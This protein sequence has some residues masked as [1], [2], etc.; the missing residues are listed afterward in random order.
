MLLNRRRFMVLG[1]GAA[2]AV[3]VPRALGAGRITPA[4]AATPAPA[5]AI[6]PFAAVMP[7]PPVAVPVSVRGGTDVYRLSVRQVAAEILPGHPT[8]VLSYGSGLIGPTIRA[9]TGRPTVVTVDS[10]VADP[11]NVHLHG[12]H[13]APED[14][15]APMDTIA[16]GA[17]RHYHYPNRQRAATYWYHDHAHHLEAEHSYRGLAGFYLLED[18]AE[19]ALRLPDGRYDVPILL[20]DAQLDSNGGLV[21]GSPFERTTLLA[22][23]VPVPRFPVAA[24]KYRF[25]L[26]NAANER[27]LQLDLGGA[28][29]IQVGTDG[30]L[31]PAPVPRT[32]LSL[33]SAERVDVVIDFS[34]YPVGSKLVLSDV[35]GPVLRF[36]VSGVARDHSRVPDR[37]RPLPA[38][39]T[40]TVHREI[41]FHLDVS[42][43][44]PVGLVDGK[45]YDPARTDMTV[46]RGSTETWT[47]HN[48]D[49]P[50]IA[51]PHTFHLH[52]EQFRVLARNGGAPGPD[53]AGLRDTVQIPPGGSVT[54]QTTF[55]DYVGKYLY[56]CHFAEHADY[57]MMATLN[58]VP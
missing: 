5:P 28:E 18:P 3:I 25:R 32:Q 7:L 49:K 43:A 42:G 38:L 20:R 23:G 58:I 40:P 53:D 21:F 37:L 30:G 17:S 27:V 48:L 19:R 2:G 9:V 54:V 29:M 11:I 44:I 26:L 10:R 24:R 1:G 52:L 22:N 36:D 41:G 46:K 39:P 56:H 14:D 45:P 55:T 34:R 8:P 16:T 12:G 33:G 4:A 50:P 15:G 13:V 31:L 47:I 6:T 35:T 51:I 57:G